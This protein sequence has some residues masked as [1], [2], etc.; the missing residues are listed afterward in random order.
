M[1]YRRHASKRN[2]RTGIGSYMQSREA[3]YCRNK[4]CIRTVSEKVAR[5]S[6]ENYGVVLC[7]ECQK[8]PQSERRMS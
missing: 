8:L 1:I 3:D 2:N 4:D 7:W 6:L 5:Y